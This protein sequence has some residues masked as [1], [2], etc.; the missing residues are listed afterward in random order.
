MG[1]LDKVDI[2]IIRKKIKNGD[3]VVMLTD[4][5][6]DY[7]NEAAGRVDWVVDYL[8]KT[9]CSNPKDLADEI[10]EKAKELSEGKVKDDMTVVVSKVYALY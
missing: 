10:M 5:I 8:Q 1:V 3:I 4:G 2:D 9:N 7:S 6:L